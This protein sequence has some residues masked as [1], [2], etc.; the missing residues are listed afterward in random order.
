MAALAGWCQGFAAGGEFGGATAFM[1]EHATRRRGFMASFQF[2]SQAISQMLGSGVALAVTQALPPATVS[3]WGFRLPFLA[4]LLIGPV[5][6]YLRRHADETP[7]FLRTGPAVA[8]VA[9][10][11]RG[12]PGRIALASCTVAAGTVLTYLRLYLPTYAQHELHMRA[13][14]SFTV[15][16]AASFV[17]L[18]VT[19]LS[20]TISD[21]VGRF[22]PAITGV[23][24]LALCAYPLFLLIDA[25]PTLAMLMAVILG[26][27]ALQS[28]YSAPIPALMG[29][30]FPPSVRG[31][32]MSVGYSLGIM[33]FGGTTPLIGTWLVSATGN[34]TMPGIYLAVAGLVTLAALLA[35]RRFVPLT[36]DQ[37]ISTSGARGSLLRAGPVPEPGR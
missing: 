22:W 30:M 34:R 18:F 26:L 23:A 12:Y 32:G 28:I 13:A 1:M 33:V 14:S 35:V 4:G 7:V 36:Q 6:L 15:P 10:A 19:P 8:P 29:E 20:A 25:V 9:A 17:G 21:R 16:L 24:L 2:T 31:V 27:S 5:G 37:D 11:L 3:D